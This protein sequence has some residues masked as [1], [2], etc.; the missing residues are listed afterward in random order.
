[1][2]LPSSPAPHVAPKAPHRFRG[3]FVSDAQTRATYA[4]ASG[5]FRVSPAAVARP[6]DPEDLCTLVEWAGTE[7]ISLIPRGGGTGMPG[8]NVGC[9]VILD[10]TG[11]TSLADLDEDTRSVWAQ[12]GVLADDLAGTGAAHGL[13]FPALPSS[14]DRCR[15]GGMVAN[16]AAG[17]R[18]FGYGAVKAWVDA[19][20][21]VLADG[22]MA[23]LTRRPHGEA[24]F[25]ALHR[26]VERSWGAQIRE[27]WPAVRKNSSGFALDDFLPEGDPV[28]LMVG[29]EGALGIVTRARMRLAPEPSGRAVVLLSLPSLE[30]LTAVSEAAEDAGAAA[31][32]FFDRRFI[33]IGGLATSS[34]VEG[35]VEG[36]AALMMVELD[37]RHL[38]LAD[39]ISGFIAAIDEMGL[40]S[41][42]AREPAE[43]QRIWALRHA[44][45]PAVAARAAEG[46]VSMQFI[47]DGV[48]PQQALPD[49]LVGVRGILDREETD[50]VMFGHAGDG[51]VHVNPLIDVHRADWRECVARILDHTVDLVVSL[52]GT[53]SGEHGDGRLRSPFHPRIWG[54][55]L[56]SAFRFVKK[57]LDPRGILNPGVV[58]SVPGQN[59]LAGLSPRKAS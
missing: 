54:R 8:G 43:R 46:L 37:D 11:W 1:M 18:S 33:E 39:A 16:N 44:A 40:A 42:V 20:D 10:L 6:R 23:R 28:S 2:A 24:P 13:F 48:V 51:N 45:S 47:E 25:G 7:G 12:P 49:Y 3:D 50:A 55:E 15:V 38:P 14:S 9:G 21:V 22:S 58:V 56:D 35:L 41:R 36:A 52:G 57:S 31:C 27:S 59:P 32:E 34:E 30:A 19:V 53:L 26:H 17:A 4:S 5:P 29:S